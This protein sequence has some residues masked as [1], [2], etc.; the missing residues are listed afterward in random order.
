MSS[1]D[2]TEKITHSRRKRSKKRSFRIW[3]HIIRH[4]ILTHPLE[5][6]LGVM[7]LLA[8]LLF[9]NPFPVLD[10]IFDGLPFGLGGFVSNI[11]QW[12]A[13]EGGAQWSGGIFVAVAIAIVA[14]RVRQV[15]LNRQTL[16]SNRCPNCDTR[17]TL[18]R[19][20]RSKLDKLLNLL[21]IPAR[22]Y[23]CKSCRWEGRRINEDQL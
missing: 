19:I 13:Y 11:G 3:L 20:H 16:W 10:T 12:V 9:A 1:S 5:M 8:V 23:R 22:R 17:F 6:M 18:K 2:H 14:I 15:F 21:F 7:V 4:W